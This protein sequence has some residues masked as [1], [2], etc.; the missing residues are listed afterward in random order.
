MRF[1]D[2]AH[3]PEMLRE[4][5]LDVIRSSALHCV[6]LTKT[7]MFF[8]SRYL[9]VLCVRYKQLMTIKSRGCRES[10][11]LAS[12]I[13]LPDYKAKNQSCTGQTTK[14]LEAKLTIILI[15]IYIYLMCFRVAVS[16]RPYAYSL[17]ASAWTVILYILSCASI[18]SYVHLTALL[19]FGF[20]YSWS[21]ITP[22]YVLK[23]Y[24]YNFSKRRVVSFI[25]TDYLAINHMWIPQEWAP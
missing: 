3:I 22:H 16:V 13:F 18:V 4:V 2:F 21:S 23:W 12:R 20:V 24:L 7:E 15:L 25:F 8:Q 14:R 1:F 6:T 10:R 19:V 11:Q 9:L 17:T 5:M